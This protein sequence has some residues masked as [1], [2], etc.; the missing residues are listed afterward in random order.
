MAPWLS[1]YTLALGALAL[2]WVGVSAYVVITRALFDVAGLSFHTARRVLD[3]RLARGASPEDALAGL[4]QRTLAGIAADA[5]TPA[6]LAEAAARRLLVRRRGRIFNQARSHKSETD[7]WRR[8]AALRILSLAGSKVARPELARALTDRDPEVVGGAVA[9]LGARSDLESAALLVAAL[10]DGRTSRSRIA[11]QLDAFPVPVSD[12]LRPLLDDPDPAIRQWG[13]TLLGRYPIAEIELELATLIVDE[14]PQVRAAVL[15]SLARN[16][17]RFAAPAAVT[18]LEDP[19]WFVRVHAA[20]ALGRLG[21]VDQASEVVALLADP[22]WWVRTA[23]KES[24]QELGDRATPAV[25]PAL[26]SDDQ[27]VRDGAAEVLQNI[28]VVDELVPGSNSRRTTS[29]RCARCARSSR[30]AVR[31]SPAR[32]SSARSLRAH[33]AQPNC[34]TASRSRPMQTAVYW[35]TL[36]C[37]AYMLG[38]F[39]ISALMLIVSGLDN[40]IRSRETLAED[41]GALGR[42][43]FAPP[44]SVLIPAYNE[45]GMVLVTV[46]SVLAFDYPEFEVIIVD[47]G[48]TDRT[49]EVLERELDLEPFGY[50]ERRIVECAP[51]TGVYRSRAHEHVKVIRKENGGTKADAANCGLNYARYRYVLLLDGDT[52]YEPDALLNC[53]RLAA[54]DPKRVIGITGHIAVAS[55]P[56]KAI[57]AR[58]EDRELI[59]AT[60]LSNFQHLE[61]LRSFLNTRLGWS[62]LGFMMCVSGAFGLWRRDIVEEVGG[63]ST[64][65]SCEDIELTSARTSTCADRQAVPDLSIPEMVA[66]TEAPARVGALLSQRARWQR[67]V[68]ETF[69]S[70]RRMICNPRYGF[71]GLVGVPVMLLSEG[72]GLCFEVLGIATLVGRH[73]DGHLLVAELHRLL[74]LDGVRSRRVDERRRLDGGHLDPCLSAAAHRA[75]AR[76][77]PVRAAPLPA[78]P[79]VGALPRHDRLLPE[80]EGLGQVRPATSAPSRFTVA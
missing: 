16:G 43:R 41:F 24:L 67:V 53:M 34:S 72:L 3:R 77:R 59:D 58:A 62:R 68:L 8:L 71:V 40:A 49:F 4:P 46:Q 76:A 7:K 36:I 44:V 21:Q 64:E 20:R 1:T 80:R 14:D 19:V 47:D 30:A 33:P 48:S 66:R 12:L 32:R 25:L 63:W 70:Y 10:R 51:V 29:W 13:A 54:S 27:F 11:A 31:R 74:R 28:G 37:L 78:D 23:A 39:A 6:P 52:L 45:E 9:I 75:P 56:E 26:K 38:L 22:Q 2:L 57:G 35:G 65:F 5:S 15:K 60:L 61:Y 79:D 69:W 73:R 55:H 18:A 17:S 42:S 50:Y